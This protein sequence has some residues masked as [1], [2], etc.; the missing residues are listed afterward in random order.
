MSDRHI[1]P[2]FFDYE[3]P[4][5]IQEYLDECPPKEVVIRSLEEGI[6]QSYMVHIV[7]IDEKR[8]KELK[9]EFQFESDS[10]KQFVDRLIERML[11]NCPEGKVAL[12]P[13]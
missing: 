5:G 10:M 4:E 3:S 2:E 8:T 11:K 12:I 13:Y 6:I 9:E 7:G 1:V